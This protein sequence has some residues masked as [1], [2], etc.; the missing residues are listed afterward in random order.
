MRIYVMLSADRLYKPQ[1]LYRLCLRRSAEI[2]GMAEVANTRKAGLASKWRRFRRQ[3]KFW[4]VRGLF[5]LGMQSAMKKLQAL[6]PRHLR[7]FRSLKEVCA[8][9]E[10]DYEMVSD[11]ASSTFIEHL[12]Q[13]APD[14]IVSFQH[15]ILGPE[16][17][18]LAEIG[19]INCHPAKLPAYRGVK[20]IFWAMLNGDDEIGVT[21]HSMVAEIDGGRTVAQKCFPNRPRSSLLENYT[22]AY[23]MAAELILEAIAKLEERPIA[24]FPEMPKVEAYYNYPGTKDIEH[25]R[26]SHQRVV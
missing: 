24:D 16:L 13:L 11:T 2:C 23:D 25:F 3:L 26:Q 22:A 14:V 21:V 15:Q 8:H 12:R 6:S 1:L 9:F 4:G 18:S 19:C 17:L 10:V 7:M 5:W 20:P